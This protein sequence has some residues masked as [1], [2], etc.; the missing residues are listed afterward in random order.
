[1]GGGKTTG[2][3][4]CLSFQPPG[5]SDEVRAEGVGNRGGARIDAELGQDVG[6]VGADGS[7]RDIELRR[8]V[9]SG[10]PGGKQPKDVDLPWRKY[11]V[12]RD[13]YLRR[14]RRWGAGS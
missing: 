13:D 3:P 10:L 5:G 9:R 6:D 2:P 4:K 7:W 14:G 1:M 12:A 11:V 8:D